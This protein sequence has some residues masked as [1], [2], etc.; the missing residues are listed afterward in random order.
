MDDDVA[1]CRLIQRALKKRGFS[2]ETAVSADEGLTRLRDE[3]FDIVAIDNYMPAKTGRQMLDEIVAMECHPPV[4]FVTGNDDTQIAVEAIHAGASDF[5]VKTVGEGF[6]DLLA[7]RFRQAFQRSELEREKRDAQAEL[8][9]ANERLEMLLSEVNHRV[10]NSLQLILN[11]VSMQANQTDEPAAKEALAATTNR[12][13][14][15]TKVHH[16][17]YTRGDPSTIDLDEY[18][19]TLVEEL[20]TSLTEGAANITIELKVEPV[21]VTPDDAVSVGVI[22]NELVGNAAKYAFP[23]KASGIICVELEAAPDGGFAVTVSD[24]GKGIDSLEVPK[25]TGLGMRIVK[26]IAR[27]LETE[28]EQVPCATGAC[29]RFVVAGNRNA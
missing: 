13:K 9:N 3:K 19:A 5:V 29:Q 22:V 11:F 2:V 17:L 27:G 20:Q 26:A 21:E 28:L 8:R 16:R 25:G 7:S 15:I 10:S 6:F 14:A 18:L 23:E 4:V 1:L 24:N 12:I